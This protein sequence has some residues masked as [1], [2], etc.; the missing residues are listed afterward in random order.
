MPFGLF[1]KRELTI[2]TR[3]GTVF[4]DRRAAACMAAEVI[5]GCFAVWYWWDWDRE[6]VAGAASFGFT[7][8]GALVLAE[9]TLVLAVIP[10]TAAP[11]IALERDKKSL[12]SLLATRVSA[13]DVVLGALG[14]TLLR[15]GNRLLALAPIVVLIMFLGGIDPRLAA[16]AFAGV[17]S[18][19]IVTASLSVAISAGARTSRH[20]VSYTVSLATAWMYL[21]LLGVMAVPRLWPAVAPWIVPVAARMLDGSPVGVVMSLAGMTPRGPL[22]PSVLKMIAIHAI[23]SVALVA[24]AIVRLRP[25]SRAIHDLEG[26]EAFF[27]SL[28]ARWRPW[29]ACGDDPVLWHEMHSARA[30]GEPSDLLARLVNVGLIG[31]LAYVMW[32]FAAPAF[33]EL[34]QR[35]YG[36][37]PADAAFPELNPLARMLVAK[38]SRF[39]VIVT[40]GQARLDFNI[41]LRQST[42]LLGFVYL[43]MLA[44]T[45][46]ESVTNERDRD[47]WLGLITTPLTGW[48]I[49]RAKM[50]GSIWKTRVMGYVILS[51]W[52]LGLLT[53]A[54]HPLG[55]A[56][57]VVASGA[58]GGFVTALGV[59]MSLW[60][61]DRAQASGRV[62]GPLVLS[63]CLGAV[64]FLLPGPVSGVAAAGS[65]P[66]QLWSALFSYDDVRDLLHARGVSQFAVAGVRSATAAWLMLAAWLIGVTA[67]AVAAVL[68]T[69]A[70]VRG[71]DAAVDRPVRS[72]DVVRQVETGPCSRPAIAT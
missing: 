53:G 47:T 24:W 71:F 38:A 44:G 2:S 63:F 45:A 3:R 7:M 39:P 15:Y 37:G 50:L 28:R 4:S 55:F 51:I 23:A 48:E 56:A 34:F 52:T 43:L 61:K 72:R 30:S 70:A 32:L 33:A 57:V 46:A 1:L 25:A 41:V 68:L 19:A 54:V 59:S 18:T 64:P 27:R 65:P 67:Q 42:G 5:G 12:D 21:P 20:A 13:A 6:S 14:A 31:A 49:L 8:F 26:R 69:R 22:V 60:S 58:A 10:M 66:F 9:L 40:P 11:S 17:A 29:P 35:G 36:P 62:I 16:L